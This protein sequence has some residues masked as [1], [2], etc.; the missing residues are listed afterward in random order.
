MPRTPDQPTADVLAGFCP[1]VAD[2]FRGRFAAPSPIQH[3]AWPVIGSHASALLIA[4]TGSG[5]TLAA[6]LSSIDRLCQQALAGE[7]LDGVQTLYITPLKA[8]GNDIERNLLAPLAEIQQL[9]GKAIDGIRVAVRSGDTPQNE[10][11]RMIRKPPHILITTPESLY[12]LLSSKRIAPALTTIRTVIVDEVHAVC[13]NKRGTHLALSLER[14][15]R[16]L[17]HPLQR[18]GCSATTSPVDEV[19]AFLTGCEADGT[20]RA[21][22]ILDAGAR[23]DLDVEVAAPVADFLAASHT[24]LW[25]SAYERLLREIRDHRTTLIFCN[26]RYKAERTALHLRQ[27]AEDGVRIG[28]HHGSMS[29]EER[30]DAEARLKAGE[31]DA[32]VATSSLELGIDVGA[33][34]LVY[35]LESPKSVAAGLQRVGRAGHLLDRTSKGRILVFERDEL[36]EAAVVCR[37]MLDGRIDDLKIPRNCLD[38]LTQQ[39][40]GCVASH[41]WG[42]DELLALVRHA[43][44]YRD[45][46][47]EDYAS[48]LGMMAGECD[49]KMSHPPRALLLW[50]RVTSRVSTARSTKQITGMCVGTIAE[51]SE[52]EVVIEQTKR[53][54]GRVQAEFVDDSLRTGDIFVL[55]SSSWRVLG[56]RRNRVLVEEA[57]GATPTVPWWTGP[58]ESRSVEVGR[59]VGRLRAM[60]AERLDDPDL[61]KWLRDTYKLDTNAA[62]AV[63]EYVREQRLAADCVPSEHEFLAE[64]WRDELGRENLILHCPLGE[65]L[66]RTWGQ[67]MVTDAKTRL[68]QT[69][70][71]TATNDLVLLM[72]RDQ[73][74]AAGSL[75]P[76][77]LIAGLTP[78]ALDRIELAEEDTGG[79]PFRSVA[80][81]SLQVL[82]GKDGKRTPLWLQSYRAEELHEAARSQ[83]EHPVLREV[84]RA[85]LADSLDLP[86]LRQLLDQL[87]TEGIKVQYRES[88]SPSPFS[89]SLLIRDLYRSGHEMGRARRAHLLRLHRQVLQGILDSDQMAELL[90]PRASERVELVRQRRSEK[91]RARNAEELAKVFRD[92]GDLPARLD[93]VQDVVE[94]D[95][96]KLLPP[97][98]KQGRIV[99]FEIPDN[100]EEPLR[101]IPTEYWGLYHAAFAEGMLPGDDTVQIPRL[102]AD[103]TIE[104]KRRSASNV[105]PEE[106]RQEPPVQDARRAILARYLAGNGPLSL[107]DLMNR[108]GWPAGRIEGLLSGL[109]ESGEVATGVYVGDKPRPQWVNRV[110]LEEIHRRT[111][112]YLKHELAACTPYEVVDFLTRWQ[113]RHPDHQLQGSDGV[114]EVIAQLQGV[115]VVSGALESEWLAGRVADY[116]PELLDR[117]I[118]AGEVCW[119]RVDPKRI[120]RGKVTL[121]LRRDMA[122]L[123]TGT[124]PKLDPEALA[125]ADIKQEIMQVRQF[126]QDA[127]SAFFADAVT[128]AGLPEDTVMRAVWFLA[129]I[130]ELTCDTY[131]CLRHADFQ[132]TLSDCYDLANTSRKIV[133]GRISAELPAAHM[134]TRR[135]DPALGRWSATERLIPPAKPMPRH[136]VI[137]RWADQL[138]CRWGILTRDMLDAEDCAPAW[139]EL[140]PELKR[141]ELL[142]QLSRGYYIESHQPNQYGL[143]EAIELLRDCRA[144]RSDRAELGYLPDEP[145]CVL[146]NRD[147]ANLYSSSLQIIEERGDVFK[148][149][150]KSGN[151]VHRYV[152]QAGQVL[153]FDTSWDALQL[154]SLTRPQLTKALKLLLA[155]YTKRDQTGSF[156]SWNRLPIDVSP[157]APLL[158]K[159]GLRFDGRGNLVYPPG[160]ATGEKPEGR[161][162]STYEPYYLEKHPVYD[163]AWVLSRANEVI[164]PLTESLLEWFARALPEG[165]TIHYGQG[166]F[167]VEYR[168]M[169][170]IWPYCQKKQIQLHIRMKGWRPGVL[171]RPD[172]DLDGDEF[173]TAVLSRLERVLKQIDEAVAQKEAKAKGP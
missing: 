167:R 64:A 65:R 5:K 118:A 42:T 94:G 121:C 9:G 33:I 36:F 166:G 105:I 4:P 25:A 119:R 48:V 146:S 28:V 56:K 140:L 44:P 116:Q 10:R 29:K 84:R 67:A 131:E 11:Q 172:T 85:F 8:L 43:Y 171:V 141:R 128:N 135:L 7:L 46:S 37:D 3:Q 45:L 169:C 57:P 147:P 40:A 54:V 47:E 74:K 27:L 81:T 150:I 89:H 79:V 73:T 145:M 58:I 17:D 87:A 31:L 52:Y 26:S 113:H 30:L 35:Q 165:C 154:T 60:V 98:L 117:L 18:I 95:A 129:W 15:Q 97:L 106:F 112:G 16:R 157:V 91:T 107:Y 22:T 153:V 132:S 159:L 13:D 2:W 122:W 82:R 103:D 69:F 68:K 133:N 77:E 110:N 86:G 20:P 51:S 1:C 96:A 39:I 12:L 136:L 70:S 163:R 123:A 62:T 144:R 142:G 170:C 120:G 114:R 19:A 93:A 75:D 152:L 143:P 124:Q 115:E 164:R 151:V 76:H 53:R 55:G 63:I 149:K 161:L 6:F 66:N 72:R 173:R 108:T 21:C 38:V 23:R 41:D 50:D 80:V 90:D 34:D 88:E 49:L 125:D 99:G 78:D 61:H 137:R 111:L 14:L 126:F 168:G 104:V 24:A 158:W 130:G 100:E 138:L 148:R 71:L 139:G 102:S 83:T 134:R 32:L 160:K 155:E 127:G 59:G 162:K 156:A 92:L 101:L 109:V